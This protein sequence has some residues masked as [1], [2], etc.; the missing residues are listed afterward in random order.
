MKKSIFWLCLCIISYQLNA[1]DR[2]LTIGRD[3]LKAKVSSINNQKVIYYLE[4]DAKKNVVELSRT[5]IHKII[6]RSG[7]EYVINQEL[8]EKLK[9]ESKTSEVIESKP[10]EEPK[11][12]E[13]SSNKA[14]PQATTT[15]NYPELRVRRW[16]L[17][18]TYTVNGTRVSPD[19]MESA[20][21]KYDLE[22]YND[23]VNGNAIRLKG[24]KTNWLGASLIV[25][26]SVLY[27]VPVVSLATYAVGNVICIIALVKYQKGIT[28]MRRSV[29][30]YENR[31]I[32]KQIKPRFN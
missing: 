28:I 6:W 17:W 27:I 18:R 3:T 7:L 13:E 22:S 20:L 12:V 4:S 32:N 5:S 30:A 19:E 26:S 24:K 23:F 14:V 2:I 21:Y 31:R 9:K 15:I 11:Q 1:Q 8:E 29:R 10:K 25:G 16:I